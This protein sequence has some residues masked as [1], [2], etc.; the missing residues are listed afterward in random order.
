MTRLH[1]LRFPRR[2]PRLR[3]AAGLDLTVLL[4]RMI[5]AADSAQAINALAKNALSRG[6]VVT[7]R[8]ISKCILKAISRCSMVLLALEELRTS[9][10]L[11]TMLAQKD[12]LKTLTRFKNRKDIPLAQSLER[13]LAPAPTLST[14]ELIDDAD[15]IFRAATTM[16]AMAED[17]AA[18]MTDD[19]TTIPMIAAKEPYWSR[20]AIETMHDLL[21]TYTYDGLP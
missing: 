4:G 8:D 1:R 19:S 13:P 16:R 2:T 18:L 15:T 6:S 14:A 3:V 20:E 21:I 5:E 9:L 12:D 7:M 11:K 10:G 17:I